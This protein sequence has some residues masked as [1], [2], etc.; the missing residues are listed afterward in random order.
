MVRVWFFLFPFSF[1][2]VL[3]CFCFFCFVFLLFSPFLFSFAVLLSPLFVHSPCLFCLFFPNPCLSFFLSF[4]D[5]LSNK[6]ITYLLLYLS[7]RVS[8]S[9]LYVFNFFFIFFFYFS[10]SYTSPPL[11]IH[12]PLLLSSSSLPFPSSRLDRPKIQSAVVP[13][14]QP[15][16]LPLTNMKH[17]SW[18]MCVWLNPGTVWCCV[19][20]SL[21]IVTWFSALRLFEPQ[22]N[23]KRT[24]SECLVCA[25][26]NWPPE[27]M[28]CSLPRECHCHFAG[29]RTF[30]IQIL[31]FRCNS[32]WQIAGF[33][34]NILYF[35][36]ECES[37]FKTFVWI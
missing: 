27:E 26:F 7:I 16:L 18:S 25:S 2:S 17:S 31:M 3:F 24:A 4:T 30:V 12:L 35:A 5:H 28:E 34:I 36:N 22:T 20:K 8:I 14:D 10:S 9:L 23:H 11:L 33:I 21:S 29:T 32:Q 15:R 13:D 6:F 37:H 1:L 19:W